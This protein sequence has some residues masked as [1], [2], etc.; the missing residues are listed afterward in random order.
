MSRLAA[1]L[2]SGY[3]LSALAVA[4]VA[5]ALAAFLA[6]GG[7]SVAPSGN[8]AAGSQTMQQGSPA[9]PVHMVEYADFLCPYCAKFA[10][11]TMPSVQQH[12][13]NSGKLQLQFIPVAVIAP[14]SQRAAEGAYCAAD[15]RK[16]WNYYATAYRETW[17]GYY[18]EGKKPADVP[19]FHGNA[20]EGLAQSA[21]LNLATFESCIDSGKYTATVQND[22]AAFEKRGF[23]G[24]PAFLINNTPYQGY[25][26]YSAV[27][28]VIDSYLK[29]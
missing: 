9:A 29:G 19:L 18:A 3:F 14:D 6:Y 27:Q 12:Y 1:I 26:P 16:F 22:T 11:Q 15:Q 5:G 28:P 7:Q 10:S 13:V 21:G 4:V 23:R 2:R 24:T 20:I 8:D 25:V 17:D